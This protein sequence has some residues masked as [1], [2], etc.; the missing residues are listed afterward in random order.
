MTAPSRLRPHLLALAL[1]L[2]ACG[3]GSG[4]SGPPAFSAADLAGD[5]HYTVA[6]HGP[7]VASGALPAYVRGTIRFDGAGVGTI[8]DQTDSAGNHPSVPTTQWAVDGSGV[9]TAPTNPRYPDL[10][11]RMN[12]AKDLVV[13]TATHLGTGASAPTLR[14]YQK[15]APGKAWTLAEL[16]GTFSVHEL[17][18]G[19]LSGWEHQT[20]TVGAGGSVAITDRV[21][22]AGSEPDLTGIALTVAGDGTVAVVGDPSWTGYLSPRGDLLVATHAVD[23]ASHAFGLIVIVREASGL[24]TASLA[25]GTWAAHTL[26][27]QGTAGAWSYGDVAASATGALAF[28]GWHPVDAQPPGGSLTVSPAGLLTSVGLPESA[29]HGVLGPGRDLLV[30]TDGATAGSAALTLAVR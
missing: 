9:V 12:A 27:E 22:Q 1:G 11:G 4:G 3:G 15:V 20:A 19:G 8:L 24:S 13:A 25:G 23:A 2:A 21:S 30:A 5:W 10:H 29:F 18:V 26:S 14:V 16:A 7:A 17:A 28:S 6:Y